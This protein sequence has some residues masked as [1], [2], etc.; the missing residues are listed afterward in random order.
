MA[1]QRTEPCLKS[2]DNL[3]TGQSF[4]STHTAIQ[5]AVAVNTTAWERMGVS[6]RA[7]ATVPEQR[8][9][10]SVKLFKFTLGVAFAD[11]LSAGLT[12]LLLES[13]K[14]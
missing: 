14:C 4:L 5:D 2:Q 13:A 9:V 1:T 10:S 12:L 7:L 11:T 6:V 3:T 8:E